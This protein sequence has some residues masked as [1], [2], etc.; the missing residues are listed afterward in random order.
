MIQIE[1]SFKNHHQGFLKL[2]NG[3]QD[4]NPE[5]R[6]SKP[7]FDVAKMAI[8]KPPMKIWPSRLLTDLHL[9]EGRDQT[10]H[11]AIVKVGGTSLLRTRPILRESDARL[12][13]QCITNTKYVDTKKNQPT[14]QTSKGT[15]GFVR[16]PVHI[17]HI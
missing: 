16:N 11:F 15:P 7:L 8:C 4:L 2:K 3:K 1:K 10:P 14:P 9:S 12:S 6:R 13:D 17:N 5:I